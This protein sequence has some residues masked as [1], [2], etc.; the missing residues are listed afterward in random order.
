MYL[1]T[2]IYFSKKQAS[3]SLLSTTLFLIALILVNSVK[4]QEISSQS[5]VEPSTKA[6][7]MDHSHMPIAVPSEVLTPALSLALTKDAMSGYNLT[8]KTARYSLTPPPEGQTMA[9]MMGVALNDT[10]GFVEGHAHLYINGIK[11]QRVYGHNIHLPSKLFK[12]GINNISVTLNNHGHMYWT[13]SDKKIL[14]TLYINEA[15]TPFISY[16]FASFPVN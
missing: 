9:Q 7:K 2:K 16:E 11:I 8:L 5:N 3:I 10:T 14:A 1:F 6:M 4:A 12:A 15:K 13:A